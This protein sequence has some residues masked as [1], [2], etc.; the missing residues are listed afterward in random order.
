MKKPLEYK[1]RIGKQWILPLLM[2][3][4]F[5]PRTISCRLHQR[6]EFG[7]LLVLRDG[8]CRANLGERR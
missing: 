2:V 4:L 5:I 1:K 6:G 3:F 8:F 7:I